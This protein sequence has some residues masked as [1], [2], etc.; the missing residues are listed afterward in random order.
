MYMCDTVD[1]LVL[2]IVVDKNFNEIERQLY[3]RCWVAVILLSVLRHTCFLFF[4]DFLKLV[5]CFIVPK[6]CEWPACI[7]PMVYYS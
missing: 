2:A 7:L 1:D 5:L 6:E 4:L 3:S